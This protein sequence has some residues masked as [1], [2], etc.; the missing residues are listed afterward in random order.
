VTIAAESGD[1]P[2][3][4]SIGV[5]AVDEDGL[6]AAAT[7][8]VSIVNA[9]PTTELAVSPSRLY[10]GSPAIATFSSVADPSA[11]DT[12][13]GFVYAF[14]CAGDGTFDGPASSAAAQP[15]AYAGAGVPTIHSR[16]QDK[17]GGF[18]DYTAAVTVLTPRQ[19]IVG[20]MQ[21]V[22]D[23]WSAGFLSTGEA[24]SLTAKL[25]AALTQRDNGN[26]GAAVNQLN[27]FLNELDAL[28]RSG[29]L[30][31]SV[32]QPIADETRLIVVAFGGSTS[33]GR[34]EK[35]PPVRA[36]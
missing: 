22:A 6:A 14:D 3:G 4:F 30:A 27:A 17:D 12:A 24:G 15:C 25:D 23:L 35:A 9:P 19:G 34:R 29:R 21:S 7:A 10:V 1:G 18:R 16:I 32:A 8:P 26:A 13:A 5:R 31:A 11:A 20:A 33:R 28:V 2:G 36:R